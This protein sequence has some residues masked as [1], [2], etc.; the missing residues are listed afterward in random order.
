MLFLQQD[1]TIVVSP[2]EV[3]IGAHRFTTKSK[4]NLQGT[5]KATCF[6]PAFT[7]SRW[8]QDPLDDGIHTTWGHPRP[9]DGCPLSG[10]VRLRVRDV[11]TPVYALQ[12]FPRA[13]ATPVVSTNSSTDK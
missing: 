11:D 3:C 8:A 13:K 10:N 12:G 2:I 6:F 5:P 4:S 7:K 1:G 9:L